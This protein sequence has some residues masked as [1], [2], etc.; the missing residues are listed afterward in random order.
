M[1]WIS[2]RDGPEKLDYQLITVCLLNLVLRMKS[3]CFGHIFM[4]YYSTQ[5]RIQGGQI[6]NICPRERPGYPREVRA[7]HP[8]MLKYYFSVSVVFW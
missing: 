3:V 1:R 2:L 5:G 6:P 7:H 4:D 8:L